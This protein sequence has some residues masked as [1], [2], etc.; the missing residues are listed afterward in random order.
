MAFTA[1]QLKHM[2]TQLAYL[3]E[4]VKYLNAAIDY[5]VANKVGIVNVESLRLAKQ[6]IT[7][8]THFIEQHANAGK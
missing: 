6:S 5:E 8:Q 3:L 4:S 1:A 7:R 2:Q